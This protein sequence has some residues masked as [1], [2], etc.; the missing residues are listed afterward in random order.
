MPCTSSRKESRL[1]TFSLTLPVLQE[2]STLNTMDIFASCRGQSL[3]RWPG[4]CWVENTSKK[5][6]GGGGAPMT[7]HLSCAL[8]KYKSLFCMMEDIWW[9]CAWCTALECNNLGSISKIKLKGPRAASS[10]RSSTSRST[11]TTTR[12]GGAR[13]AARLARTAQG[14]ETKRTAREAEKTEDTAARVLMGVVSGNTEETRK[15]GEDAQLAYSQS[16]GRD[17]VQHPTPWP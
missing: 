1:L 12:G 9:L 17:G 15:L 11:R 5:D 10:A 6:R 4:R 8:C 14:A 7:Q 13:R 16:V 2:V 3:G